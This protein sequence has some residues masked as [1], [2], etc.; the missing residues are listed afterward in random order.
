MDKQERRKWILEQAGMRPLAQAIIHHFTE[1]VGPEIA[2][3]IQAEIDAGYSPDNVAE[4]LE[5]VHFDPFVVDCGWAYAT[6]YSKG[7]I[8]LEGRDGGQADDKTIDEEE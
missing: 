3:G 1:L 5:N 7:V 8:R 4:L 6:L 2:Y